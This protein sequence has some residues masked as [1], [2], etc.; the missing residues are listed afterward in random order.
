MSPGRS[1]LTLPASCGDLA[2]LSTVEPSR[3]RKTLAVMHVAE[4]DYEGDPLRA[5]MI[6]SEP[7]FMAYDITAIIRWNLML[8]IYSVD[9]EDTVKIPMRY[10][11]AGKAAL[12]PNG[13]D[14]AV[15]FLSEYGLHDAVLHHHGRGEV[16]K[17][18]RRWV[19]D[20][21]TPTLR[22]AAPPSIQ[23]TDLP[24]QAHR[25]KVSKEPT[26]SAQQRRMER[27][28]QALYRLYNAAGELLYVGITWNV[29]NRMNTHRGL[30][31][32]WPEVADVQLETH[33]NR[34]A[35]LAAE[36]VAIERERP[37]YNITRAETG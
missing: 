14:D 13:R 25:V 32:W 29:A 34:A 31:P 16:G 19:M 23:R 20:C 35:V 21:V 33:P 26:P 1:A 12:R 17:R 18:F 7:W 37:R 28:P 11:R 15:W 3:A 30:Q 2:S 24:Y 6:D 9:V 8:A 36:R 5:I 4:F 10:L 27:T 22:E